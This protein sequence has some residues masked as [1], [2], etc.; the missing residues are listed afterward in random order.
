MGRIALTWCWTLS[1]SYPWPGQIALGLSFHEW[2]CGVQHLHGCHCRTPTLLQ[3]QH[4][5]QRT[6]LHA[7]RSLAHILRCCLDWTC[8]FPSAWSQRVGHIFL[9]DQ[10]DPCLR[11][12]RHH[13]SHCHYQN[14][15]QSHC[16]L[17]PS[18]QVVR[19]RHHCR[20]CQSCCFRCRCRCRRP[21]LQS[22][23]QGYHHG[24]GT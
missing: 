8:Y 22:N 4:Q 20:R 19:R 10:Y 1:G 17:V 2:I 12:R 13:Q 23:Q 14:R 15:F 5:G 16:R 7:L 24:C 18:T 11:R 9:D 21:L 3:A 6:R